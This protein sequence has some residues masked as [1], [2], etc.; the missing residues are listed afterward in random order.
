MPI[1]TE[2]VPAP[3]LRRLEEVAHACPP[4][5][6]A[7]C[8][9]LRPGCH[10]IRPGWFSAPPERARP[11]RLRDLLQLCRRSLDCASRRGHCAPADRVARD[12]VR[13]PLLAR[14]AL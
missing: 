13:L 3:Y 14:W 12:R 9:D 5:L 2:S 11:E 4:L 1:R 6:P 7:H 10:G 8:F